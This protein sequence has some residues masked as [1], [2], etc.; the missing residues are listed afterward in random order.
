MTQATPVTAEARPILL[1]V[2]LA[3][4]SALGPLSI[5]LYLPALPRLGDDLGGSASLSQLTITGCLIGLALGQV[6]AGPTSDRLGRRRP[7]LVGVAGYAAASLLCLVAPTVWFLI[8]ARLLQGAMGGTAIVIARAVVRDLHQGAAAARFFGSLVQVSALAPVVA[9]LAGGALLQV[10]PW[11]GLFAV[12]AGLGVLLLIVVHQGLPESLPPQAR[13]GEGPLALVA[14]FGKLAADRSFIGYALT[15]GLAF[16]ALFTYISGS[17]F[18][19]QEVYGLPRLAFAG[20]FAV[21]GAGIAV[22]GRIGSRLVDEHGPARLV[23]AGLRIAACGGL[24]VAGSLSLGLWTLLPGLFMVV[25]SIGLILPNSMALALSQR[26][27]RMAGTAAA[28]MGLSQFLLGGLAAP[29]AGLAGSHTSAPM[30]LIIAALT[31]SALTAFRLTPHPPPT[32]QH[33]E[34]PAVPLSTP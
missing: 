30:S 12:I 4:L 10:L 5:D 24:A 15:G 22:A 29:L 1:V 28:L 34:E 31:L 7:L 21:N 27:P 6:V 2:I 8:G 19:I 33:P 32:P 9:P 3:G 26:P 13:R 18:V 20:L 25:A 14:A 11:R 17:P 16:A 23:R